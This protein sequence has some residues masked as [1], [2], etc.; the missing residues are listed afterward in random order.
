MITCGVPKVVYLVGW[1]FNG[2]DSK[3]PD[4]SGVNNYL[5]R[6]QDK[7][8]LDSLRWLIREGRKYNTTVSLHLNMLDA[9]ADSPLWDEYFDLDIIAKDKKGNPL[10]AEIWGG[11]QSYAISY[12]REWETGLAARRIDGLLS[13]IPELKEGHTIHIDAFQTWMYRR[14][15]ENTLSPLLGYTIEQETEAQRRIFRYFRNLGIDVTSEY[16]TGLRQDWFIGLQPMAYHWEVPDSFS[17]LPRL[18]CSTPM[19]GEPEVSTDPKGLSGLQEQFCLKA[20]PWLWSNYLR[21]D[22]ERRKPSPEDWIRIKQLDCC[23]VPLLW[24]KEKS[25]IAFSRLNF[26]HT[27]ILPSDWK[28]VKRVRLQVIAPDGSSVHA[29]GSAKVI[30]GKLRLNL[31]PCKVLLVTDAG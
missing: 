7:T 15:N 13:M 30:D 9:Y 12:K 8:A 29:A 17:F 22:D 24:R 16:F 2:H 18:M 3:Y 14:R 5:K 26:D 1:Q 23:C 21:H 6:K 10:K 19:K 25:L 31:K 4:W 28:T 11:Q 20:A 27:W